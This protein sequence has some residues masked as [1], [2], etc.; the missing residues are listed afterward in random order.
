M[1]FTFIFSVSVQDTPLQVRFIDVLLRIFASSDIDD[2][3]SR[4]RVE[5]KHVLIATVASLVFTCIPF[6]VRVY[7]GVPFFGT[8]RPSEKCPPSTN[9]QLIYMSVFS[10]LLTTFFLTIYVF[11]M[12]DTSHLYTE[13]RQ[14]L[15]R[16][17]ALLRPGDALR[18]RVPY[19]HFDSARHIVIWAH[20]RRFAHA[21]RLIEFRRVEAFIV[22]LM[23]A[24]AIFV[25]FIF[26]QRI[27]GFAKT[28]LSV[29]SNV[30]FVVSGYLVFMVGCYLAY[31]TAWRCIQ[32]NE[33]QVRFIQFI[34]AEKW[35]LEVV[36]QRTE[37]LASELPTSAIS[38][39][40]NTFK[41]AQQSLIALSTWLNEDEIQFMIAGIVIDKKLL[42]SIITS[43]LVAFSTWMSSVLY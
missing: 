41:R 42:L 24:F 34:N 29:N 18:L 7:L 40:L 19:L 39:E 6:G 25:A 22:S 35:R 30:L 27:V 33:A 10:F 36:K 9:A 38:C 28:E 31:P 17:E 43:G 23:L 2:A 37:E 32:I 5:T 3:P 26:W 21:F 16:I 20:I 14:L 1:C 15:D 12:L 11:L 8:C 13:R 4:R